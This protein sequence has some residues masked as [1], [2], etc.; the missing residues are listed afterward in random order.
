MDV[1]FLIDGDVVFCSRRHALRVCARLIGEAM[2]MIE[3]GLESEEARRVAGE[4]F[5]V[6]HMTT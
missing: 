4:E 3:R 2:Q 1:P 6:H 5:V